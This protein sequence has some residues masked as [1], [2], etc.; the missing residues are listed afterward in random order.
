M[1]VVVLGQVCAQVLPEQVAEVGERD[2]EAG[3]RALH[4]D[5]DPGLDPEADLAADHAD[6]VA[7][8]VLDPGYLRTPHGLLGMRPRARVS[9]VQG[10]LGSFCARLG[11]DVAQ[12][13]LPANFYFDHWSP[14]CIAHLGMLN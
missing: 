1:V 4:P 13:K 7:G 8:R 3:D 9:L 5:M 2:G 6:I 10:N 14:P 12:T 11:I